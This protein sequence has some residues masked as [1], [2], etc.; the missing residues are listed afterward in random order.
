MGRRSGLLD[1]LG[2]DEWTVRDKGYVGLEN[3]MVPV[4]GR[5]LNVDER[6]WNSAINSVRVEVERCINEVKVFDC[7]RVPWRHDVTLHGKVFG[8]CG[9]LANIRMETE[10][11]RSTIN[12]WLL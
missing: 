2:P 9:H 11:L 4:K 10:P 5:H 8:I 6:V 7:L 1:R 12:P 3:A